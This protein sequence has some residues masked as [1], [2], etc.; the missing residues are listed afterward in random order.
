MTANLFEVQKQ[1]STQSDAFPYCFPEKIMYRFKEYKNM[2]L[3][4]K[5]GIWLRNKRI[6][7]MARKSY[8]AVKLGKPSELYDMVHTENLFW[9]M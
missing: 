4:I 5:N 6:Y 3:M 2:V 1:L 8:L 7:T 9:S